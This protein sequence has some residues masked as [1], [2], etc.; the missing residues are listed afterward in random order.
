MFSSL[1]AGWSARPPAC[2][3]PGD[4]RRVV[5]PAPPAPRGPRPSTGGAT[6][7]VAVTQNADGMVIRVKGEAR[8]ECVGVLLDGLLSPGRRSAVVILDLS[9]LRSISWLAVGVLAAYRR[10]VVRTGGQMRLAG[11]LQPPVKESLGR[12]ELF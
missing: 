9:D 8:V 2:A 4:R 5:A 11:V 6:L 10:S 1:L 12:S 7:K 3:A